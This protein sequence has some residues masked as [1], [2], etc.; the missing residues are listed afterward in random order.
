VFYGG[1]ILALVTALLYMRHK[2]LPAL[3]T[4]DV[5]APGVALGHAIGRLGCFSA[6]CCFGVECKRAWGV[7]FTSPRAHE[8]FGTPLNVPLHPT[9]LYEAGAEA[10][11][12]VVLYRQFY[13]RRAAGEVIGLYLLLYPLARFIVE[14]YR[15]PEQ[16]NPFGGPLTAAQWI[17]AALFATGVYL[18]KRSRKRS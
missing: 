14:F 7:T 5:Y 1:L 9:Q 12:F 6:G 16:P 8:L 2:R 3:D 11:I 13:R 10:L 4:T 18:V 15:A 17:S